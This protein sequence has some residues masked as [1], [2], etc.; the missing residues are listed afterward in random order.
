MSISK[1]LIILFCFKVLLTNSQQVNLKSAT[2]VSTIPYYEKNEY[3][4]FHVTEKEIRLENEDKVDEA[5][6]T[7]KY[8]I[9]FKVKTVLILIIR[10]K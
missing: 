10:W 5:P 6:L 3:R 1:C 4:T 2:N 9:T 8:D 7:F